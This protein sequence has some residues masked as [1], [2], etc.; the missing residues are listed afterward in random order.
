MALWERRS[1]LI[2]VFNR[3]S[4]MLIVPKHQGNIC[5]GNGL[6]GESVEKEYHDGR[7]VLGWHRADDI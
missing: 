2:N 7:I 4:D 5:A 1:V 3:L 6:A